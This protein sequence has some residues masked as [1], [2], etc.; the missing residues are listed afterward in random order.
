MTDRD[1]NLFMAFTIYLSHGSQKLNAIFL[2]VSEKVIKQ[3]KML[4]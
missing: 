3:A 4:C 1:G 2:G